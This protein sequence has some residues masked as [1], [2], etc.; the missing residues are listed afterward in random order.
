MSESI[1]LGV[2]GSGAFVLRRGDIEAVAQGELDAARV[3]VFLL[4]EH[5]AVAVEREAVDAAVEEVVTCE[6]DVET[7]TEEV[8]ADAEREYGVGAVEPC[9]LLVAVGVHVEVGL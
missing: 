1:L 8:L 9:V 7:T 4:S 6:F 3:V 2:T 5:H